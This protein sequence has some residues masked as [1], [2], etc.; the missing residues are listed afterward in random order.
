M[1]KCEICGREMIKAKGCSVAKVHCNNK[2]YRRQRCGDE[3]WV[4]PGERCPDCGA[5]YGHY[6]HWGCD[7]ERCP[8]CGMQMLGCACDNVYIEVPG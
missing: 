8:V 1:A 3:G 5:M 4:E 6:H 2:F 7:V